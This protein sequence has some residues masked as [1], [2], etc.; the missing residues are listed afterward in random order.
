MSVVSSK[1]ITTTKKEKLMNVEVTLANGE[2]SFPIY[3]PSHKNHLI[4]F[5]ATYV[6]ENP[7][8]SVVIKDDFGNV[9]LDMVG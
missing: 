5:Y 2:K 7:G 1:I 4:Q 3:E 6:N 8:S 9:V